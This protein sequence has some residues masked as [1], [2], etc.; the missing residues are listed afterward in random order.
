MRISAVGIAS[1]AIAKIN[2]WRSACISRADVKI[3]SA[4]AAATISADRIKNS[5]LLS[6]YC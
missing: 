1:H 6:K 5:G 2:S 4:I 3:H